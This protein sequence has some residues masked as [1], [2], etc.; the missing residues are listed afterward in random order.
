M[1]RLPDLSTTSV[2]DLSGETNFIA[3]A[4][5]AEAT[6]RR[7]ARKREIFIACRASVLWIGKNRLWQDEKLS[8]K[9]HLYHKNCSVITHFTPLYFGR[10]VLVLPSSELKCSTRKGPRV[11]TIY[12]SSLLGSAWQKKIARVIPGVVITQRRGKT[13]VGKNCCV[14]NPEQRILLLH[15]SF[16]RRNIRPALK[17]SRGH[18]HG[19]FR[20]LSIELFWSLLDPATGAN[21]V[22]YYLSADLSDDGLK[23]NLA[24]LRFWNS[25]GPTNSFI[26]ADSYLLHQKRL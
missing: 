3:S 8:A 10:T 18:G 14:V 9:P 17:Q 19:D 1:S 23:R 15:L 26:K 13:D 24:V 20:H 7:K 11:S 22:L 5:K 16:G 6:V 21:K 2:L 12:R 4:A 25:L